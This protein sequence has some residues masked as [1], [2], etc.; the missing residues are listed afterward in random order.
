MHRYSHIDNCD[1]EL[2]DGH[3]NTVHRR[4]H[5]YTCATGYDLCADL[6][7]SLNSSYNGYKYFCSERFNYDSNYSYDWNYDDSY[8]SDLGYADDDFYYEEEF[9]FFE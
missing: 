5:N 7:D 6:R 3:S 1:Y 4:F 9:D 2:V 8:Y